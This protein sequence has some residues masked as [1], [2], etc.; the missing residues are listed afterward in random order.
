MC[1]VQ[2]GWEGSSRA[3]D[4]LWGWGIVFPCFLLW[5]SYFLSPSWGQGVKIYRDSFFSQLWSPGR[6]RKFWSPCLGEEI[7]NDSK[8]CQREQSSLGLFH[9]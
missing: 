5:E 2:R 8:L 9:S 7:A 3:G 1:W 6:L 4:P